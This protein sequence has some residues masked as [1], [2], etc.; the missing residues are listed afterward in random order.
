MLGKS[1]LADLWPWLNRARR[2]SGLG[3]CRERLGQSW[4]VRLAML[5]AN[6][7]EAPASEHLDGREMGQAVHRRQPPGA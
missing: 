1:A 2:A 6:W 7:P 5:F 3:S 4:A